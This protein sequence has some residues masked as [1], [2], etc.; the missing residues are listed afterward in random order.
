MTWHYSQ[1]GDWYPG[2]T[3]GDWRSNLRPQ[4]WRFKDPFDHVRHEAYMKNVVQWR[5]RGEPFDLTIEEY[6]EL[7]TPELWAKRGRVRGS[8]CLTRKDI[9]QPWTRDNVEIVPRY[10][11]CNN[12]RK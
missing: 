11:S 5:Y 1:G 10:Q 8:V 3:K 9:T 4:C 2:V 7:W 12:K 6:F